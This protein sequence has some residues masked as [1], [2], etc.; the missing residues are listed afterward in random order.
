MKKFFKNLFDIFDLEEKRKIKRRSRSQWT[1]IGLAR[2]SINIR[3]IIKSG[4]SSSW[5]HL[6][7]GKVV[8][9]AKSGI[10]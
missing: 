3:K 8:A 9:C 6:P 4:S 5:F 2:F 1:K 10:R 7:S